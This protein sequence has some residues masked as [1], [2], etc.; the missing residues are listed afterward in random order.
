MGG[1]S[2]NFEANSQ[3]FNFLRNALSNM[4]RADIGQQQPKAFRIE[5]AHHGVGVHG[6]FDNHIGV[7]DGLVLVRIHSQCP[8][9]TSPMTRLGN[10]AEGA[11]FKVA[12]D[13]SCSAFFQ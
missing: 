13:S 9:I 5:V 1:D 4:L 8:R 12:G 10:R 3:Q 7:P 2:P 11:V 6:V